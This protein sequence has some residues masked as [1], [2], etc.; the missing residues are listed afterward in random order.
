MS[1]ALTIFLAL[2][3]CKMLLI[4]S[5]TL[6]S[7]ALEVLWITCSSAMVGAARVPMICRTLVLCLTRALAF[8]LMVHGTPWLISLVTMGAL[9]PWKHLVKP[10]R[11]DVVLPAVH[12]KAGVVL[13]V[14]H[15]KRE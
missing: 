9:P 13:V 14:A 11:V 10:V 3:Q 1:T 2:L 4:T 12:A 7:F 8:V 15:V 5:R 6:P